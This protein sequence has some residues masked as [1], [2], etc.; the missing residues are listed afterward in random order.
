MPADDTRGGNQLLANTTFASAPLA[1]PFDWDLSPRP[2]VTFERR[3]GLTVRQGGIHQHLEN[4][5]VPHDGQHESDFFVMGVEQQQEIV[6][7]Q[8]VTALVMV[9]QTIAR[10]V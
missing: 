8:R 1:I 10:Q 9:A 4:G 6:V 7:L 2:G 5:L 3:D